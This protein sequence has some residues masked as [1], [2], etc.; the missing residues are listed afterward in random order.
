[1]HILCYLIGIDAQEHKMI[2]Y[3]H[4]KFNSYKYVYVSTLRSILIKLEPEQLNYLLD[5]FEGF[6]KS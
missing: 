3:G 5:T 1:M 2:A 4:I 6:V